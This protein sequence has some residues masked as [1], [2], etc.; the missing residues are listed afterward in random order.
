GLLAFVCGFDPSA[1]HIVIPEQPIPLSI[2]GESV[3][4]GWRVTAEIL[5]SVPAGAESDLEAVFDAE[6]VGT[7]VSVRRR[8]PGD[9]MQPLGM[10]GSKKVQDVMVDCKV[11]VLARDGVPVVCAGENIIWL[12]GCRVDDR[13]KVA[14][15]TRSFLRLSF[16]RASA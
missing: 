9:R 15:S 6:R 8:R 1:T 13:F 12:V 4:A 14:S 5:D 11:P 7:D 2:P 10:C 16:T 3:I